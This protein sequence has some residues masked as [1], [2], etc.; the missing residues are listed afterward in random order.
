VALKLLFLCTGNSCRSQ[1][2]EGFARRDAGDLFDVYSA[3]LEPSRV[4]PRA[5]AVMAEKGVSLDGQW[6]KELDEVPAADMDLVITVC[7]DADARCPLLYG[8]LGRRHWPLPDPAKATGSEEQIMSVFRAVRD[9]IEQRV[10]ALVAE[11]AGE[12]GGVVSPGV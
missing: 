4:N 10:Q 9:D 6:S 5:I 8:R 11:L 7:G 3:G 1:M 12:Q 2:A